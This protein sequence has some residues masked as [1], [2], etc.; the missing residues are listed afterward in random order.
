MPDVVSA[1]LPVDVLAQAVKTASRVI[2]RPTSFPVT[3]GVLLDFGGDELRV[4]GTNLEVAIEVTVDT[5]RPSAEGSVVVPAKRFNAVLDKL[6]LGDVHLEVEGSDLKVEAGGASVLLHTI[7]GAEWPH[8]DRVDEGE[9]DLNDELWGHLVRAA[10]AASS[11]PAR[12]VLSGVW[13]ADGWM[14]A[15]DAY[16]ASMCQLPDD[17]LS[18]LIP[19]QALRDTARLGDSAKLA[20]GDLTATFTVGRTKVTAVL[21]HD[22]FPDVMGIVRRAQA[23]T[24]GRLVVDAAALSDAVALAMTVSDSPVTLEVRDGEVVVSNVANDVGEVSDSVPAEV[25][26]LLLPCRASFNPRNLTEAIATVC[27]A[28]GKFTLQLAQAENGTV[29]KA[30][31]SEGAGVDHLIMPIGSE[32]S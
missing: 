1:D 2:G 18:G 8:L 11:D 28:G 19:V 9:V 16:R 12:P 26:G 21:L 13:F 10:L 30:A 7:A 29:D 31:L 17:S 3:A 6:P 22:N 20:I 15:S 14:F 5:K 23:E 4:T 24:T 25:E 32:K 27:P